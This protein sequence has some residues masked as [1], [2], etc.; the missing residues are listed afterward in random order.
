MMDFDKIWQTKIK[1]HQELVD[2]CRSMCGTPWVHRGRS[3]KYG[4]DCGG[5]IILALTELGYEPHDMTVYGREPAR[6]GLTKYLNNAIGEPVNDGTI[7]VGDV[8]SMKFNH[9]PHHVGVVGNYVMGGLSLIHG[10]GEAEKVVEHILD[11][12]WIDRIV[13]VYRF[14]LL[15]EE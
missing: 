3:R 4:V 5:M 15:D 7:Q 11:K 1:S 14:K 2:Q 9:L 12:K 13:H 6:D 8:L 10:Y